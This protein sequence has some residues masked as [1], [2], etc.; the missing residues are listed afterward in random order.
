MLKEHIIKSHP[1]EEMPEELLGTETSYLPGGD[2]G[3][4]PDADLE[5]DA[6]DQGDDEGSHQMLDEPE[7]GDADGNMIVGDIN[8]D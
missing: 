3:M 1:E 2:G 6:G 5:L 8:A 7:T 4:E